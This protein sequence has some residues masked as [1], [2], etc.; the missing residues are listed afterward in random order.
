M[1]TKHRKYTPELLQE[2]VTAADSVMGVMRYLGI[3]Q[4][5]GTHAHISRKIKEF[6]I[7]TGHFVRYKG[8]GRHLRRTPEDIMQ[9]LPFGS[10]RAK[11]EFL[12]RAL[13][14]SGVSQSCARCGNDGTWE[15]SPLTLHV[16]HIN[17][18]FHDNQRQNLRFLCPNCHAQ[19]PNFA[20]R[21]KGRYGAV[22]V[23][24]RTPPA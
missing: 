11:P 4:A 18:D 10:P 13:V 9:V 12:R 19:T 14:E 24:V 16:D 2:A 22:V 21:G 20:G 17:G 6:G 5:G 7:D 8:S 15:G 1:G 3:P 23:N